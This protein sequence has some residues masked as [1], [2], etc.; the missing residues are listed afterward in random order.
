MIKSNQD[1]PQQHDSANKTL[2]KYNGGKNKK[3]NQLP[4]D[5][6]QSRRLTIP[7]AP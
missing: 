3:P 7:L 4:Q 1:A 6:R 2:P 5:N